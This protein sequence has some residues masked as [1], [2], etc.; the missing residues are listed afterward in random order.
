MLGTRQVLR[1][2]ALELPMSSSLFSRLDLRLGW[3]L[4][5]WARLFFEH[6]Y[7]GTFFCELCD[8]IPIAR[9]CL[10]LV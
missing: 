9:S 4:P 10:L 5:L 3:S 6:D 8:I 2:P 7:G 1:D